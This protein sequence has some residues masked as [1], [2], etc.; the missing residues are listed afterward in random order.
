MQVVDSYIHPEL[1]VFHQHPKQPRS[2]AKDRRFP[3]RSAAGRPLELFGPGARDA[4]WGQRLTVSVFFFYRKGE[5]ML[6]VK[7][8]IW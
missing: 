4:S 1:H 6:G 8:Q 7:R 5:V 3:A 2:G